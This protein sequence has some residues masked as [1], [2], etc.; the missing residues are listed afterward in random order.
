MLHIWIIFV[1]ITKLLL[2]KIRFRIFA[3]CR[4]VMRSFQCTSGLMFIYQNSAVSITGT[5]PKS[6]YI[7]YSILFNTK[8]SL[9][10]GLV[11][12]AKKAD[13]IRMKAW[14]LEKNYRSFEEQTEQVLNH[15]HKL[16]HCLVTRIYHF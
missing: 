2:C 9:S 6:I 13:F 3:I 4:N 14:W 7:S 1:E 8:S 10:L 11:R 12:S 15:T 5:S 16:C